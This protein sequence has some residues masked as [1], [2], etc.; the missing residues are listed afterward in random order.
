MEIAPYALQNQAAVIYQLCTNGWILYNNYVNNLGLDSIQWR[1]YIVYCVL[2]AVM[3]TTVYFIFPE[4][5]GLGLEEMGQIFGEDVTIMKEAG[6]NAIIDD[7]M[8]H[9]VEHVENTSKM[10]LKEEFDN[11]A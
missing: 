4:T 8:K 1:H 2:L 7:S 3:A 10:N 11:L 6:D 9:K 5:F